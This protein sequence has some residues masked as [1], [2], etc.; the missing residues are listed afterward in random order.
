MASSGGVFHD[1]AEQLTLERVDPDVVVG[2]GCRVNHAPHDYPGACEKMSRRVVAPKLRRH[3]RP[4]EP[5]HRLKE[6]CELEPR[7]RAVPN[8]SWYGWRDSGIAGSHNSI[9][10]LSSTWGDV[11]E[12]ASSTAA[13]HPDLTVIPMAASW[14]LG[15]CLAVNVKEVVHAQRAAHRY[16]S[17]HSSRHWE[18]AQDYRSGGAARRDASMGLMMPMWLP[19]G[20]QTMA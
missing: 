2:D 14:T 17:P 19:S 16:P 3:R 12:P 20:S 6:P 15:P 9:L 10:R 7:P 11:G 13:A 5:S 18:R 4:S 1:R 8:P